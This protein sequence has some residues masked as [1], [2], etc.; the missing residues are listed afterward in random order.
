MFIAPLLLMQASAGSGEAILDQL[1][2]RYHKLRN[3]EISI[4]KA[5]RARKGEALE[6][7][8]EMILRYVDPKKFHL[9][10]AEYWGGGSRY[11]SDGVTLLSESVDGGRPIQLRNA[12][13]LIDSHPELNLH[14]GNSSVIFAFLKGREMRSKLVAPNIPISAGRNWI[15]FASKDF[16]MMTLTLTDGWI[17]EIAYDN[18]PGRMASY[19]MTPMW[20]EKP[21]DPLEIESVTYRF[22]AK[23]AKS[24]F[25]TKPKPGL[26]VEDLRKK[27]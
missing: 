2:D 23:F 17:H 24:W 5:G 25:D 19:V 6:A 10:V 27:G 18:L 26:P 14:A 21:E 22:G 13:P 1:L 12:A 7:S 20:N 16:G 4:S 11:V 3:V 15:R 9:D 8:I